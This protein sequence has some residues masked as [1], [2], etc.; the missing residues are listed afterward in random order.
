[1]P[2]EYVP[3]NGSQ[4]NL[5]ITSLVLGDYFRDFKD[6]PSTGTMTTEPARSTT[7]HLAISPRLTFAPDPVKHFFAISPSTPANSCLRFQPVAAIGCIRQL[8]VED[9]LLQI[10]VRRFP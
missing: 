10:L 5:N 6:A 8:R 9:E 3:P 7:A 2:E 4:L 1:V